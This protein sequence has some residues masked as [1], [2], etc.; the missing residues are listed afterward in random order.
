MQFPDWK[1][2][3][4]KLYCRRLNTFVDPLLPDPEAWKVVLSSELQR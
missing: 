4:G 3:E 2:A 1:I